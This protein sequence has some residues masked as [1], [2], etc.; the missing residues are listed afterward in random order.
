MIKIN[1]VLMNKAV[2]D[3]NQFN[4]HDITSIQL[5][6]ELLVEAIRRSQ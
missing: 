2:V 5:L 1:W 6:N 4:E 3:G